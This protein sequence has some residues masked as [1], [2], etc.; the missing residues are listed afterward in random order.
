M[1]LPEP[2]RVPKF[3][4]EVAAFFNLFFVEANVLTARR[5][6]HQTEAQTV[7]AILVDQIERIGRIPER[8]RHFPSLLVAN[9]AGE[10][11]V[12][13]RNVVFS[14]LRFARFEFEAGDDHPRD[15]EEN[16]VRTS[17][18]DARWIKYLPRLLVHR[19]VSPKPR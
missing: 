17:D 3:G 19:F 13:E 9:D 2:R 4:R 11:N 14:L 6:P 5:D 16:N 10:E 7:C 18:E 1:H 8:L 15:P 12:V